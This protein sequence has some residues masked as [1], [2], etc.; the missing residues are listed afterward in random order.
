[1]TG[2]C[3]LSDDLIDIGHLKN[4][5]HQLAAASGG[6]DPLKDIKCGAQLFK[7]VQEKAQGPSFS[8]SVHRGLDVCRLINKDD[9]QTDGTEIDSHM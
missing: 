4:M 8:A 3:G 2:P 6:D 7:G 9:V 1:M 5:A